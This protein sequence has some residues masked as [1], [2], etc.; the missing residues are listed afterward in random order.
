MGYSWDYP[1][2]CEQIVDIMRILTECAEKNKHEIIERLKNIEQ[3]ME[4]DGETSV[5]NMLYYIVGDNEYDDASFDC[6]RIDLLIDVIECSKVVSSIIPELTKFN[7]VKIIV[8][9][10]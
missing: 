4:E 10:Y 2:N 8:Y 1:I 3:L 5:K 9:K 6:D 7:T